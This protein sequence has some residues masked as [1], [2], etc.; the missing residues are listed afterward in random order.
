[1]L[2]KLV[3]VAQKL[4]SIKEWHQNQSLFW[5]GNYSNKDYNPKNLSWAQVP[6]KMVSV[7]QKL[8][9][10]QEW[11]QDRSYLFQWGDYGNKGHNPET[12]DLGLSPSE[13]RFCSLETKH[14]RRMVSTPKLFI[15]AER[16]QEQMKQFL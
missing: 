16:L 1:M 12:S 13:G 15:L 4:S 7:A 3:S 10:I 8:N 9:T 2:M 6:M 14:G 11:C 5:Q